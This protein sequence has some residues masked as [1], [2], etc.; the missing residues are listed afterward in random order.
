VRSHFVRKSSWFVTKTK[1]I[2]AGLN[3]ISWQNAEKVYR[4]PFWIT[5]PSREKQFV[6]LVTFVHEIG[7]TYK[8]VFEKKKIR[9]LAMY[10]S[11]KIVMWI[12][13]KYDKLT[14]FFREVWHY[15]GYWPLCEVFFIPHYTV[16]WKLVSLYLQVRST[17]FYTTCSVWFVS[18]RWA[19][20]CWAA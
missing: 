4:N 2:L 7:R 18:A 1:C 19:A 6:V 20:T 16:I 9:H 17:Y 10:L 12:N 5:V 13:T 8:S 3:R 11:T 14:Y 15:T